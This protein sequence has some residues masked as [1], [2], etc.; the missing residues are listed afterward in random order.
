ML[1]ASCPRSFEMSESD[2]PPG[3]I[4]QTAR[5]RPLSSEHERILRLLRR[6]RLR[7]LLRSRRS[8]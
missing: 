5:D 8:A 1:R 7:E 3:W 4:V 2:L 6:K